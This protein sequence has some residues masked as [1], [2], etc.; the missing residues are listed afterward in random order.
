MPTTTLKN[1]AK[2]SG[3]PIKQVE[4]KWEEC[5]KQADK[6]FKEKDGNYWAYCNVCIQM[7]LGIYEKP[8]F[9]KW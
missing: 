8:K 3:K 1:Y 7:K 6:K 9:S 5:K 4:E 2:K